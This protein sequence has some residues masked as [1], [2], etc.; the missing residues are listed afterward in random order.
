MGHSDSATCANMAVDYRDLAA[1]HK[2]G[3][4]DCKSR[5]CLSYVLFSCSRV[6]ALELVLLAAIYPA[7]LDIIDEVASP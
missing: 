2:K 5:V 7:S 3:T 4:Q 1:A 6:T